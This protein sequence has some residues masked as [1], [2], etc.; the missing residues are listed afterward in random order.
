MRKKGKKGDGQSGGGKVSRKKAG[1]EGWRLTR[2]RRTRTLELRRTSAERG[3]MRHEREKRPSECV[4]LRKII[5][6]RLPEGR[7]T[8]R[9]G[10]LFLKNKVTRR[11]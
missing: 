3:V 2:K 4:K 10:S 5:H 1:K 7:K 6:G 11:R 9:D 8:K